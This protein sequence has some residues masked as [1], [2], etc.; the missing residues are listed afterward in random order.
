MML[1]E[2]KYIFCITKEVSGLT[3][4]RLLIS[5]NL[6]LQIIKTQSVKD[7]LMACLQI[8]IQNEKLKH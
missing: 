7:F 4:S 6:L 2:H 1:E 3:N 5:L 8:Q